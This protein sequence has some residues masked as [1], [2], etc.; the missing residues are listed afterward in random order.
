VQQL[1]F[2][3]EIKVAHS[4][5]FTDHAVNFSALGDAHTLVLSEIG[6]AIV[7]PQPGT[8]AGMMAALSTDSD[9][10][11]AAVEPETFVF[12][13]ADGWQEYLRGFA[14]A[15][16]RIQQDLVGGGAA[17]APAELHE[18]AAAAAATWGLVATRVTS[19]AF[20][21]RGIKVAVLDT[22]F[23]LHHP[24][25]AGRSI[26]AVSFISGQTAQD[27]HGHGTHTTGTACGPRAPAGGVPRYGIAYESQIFMGKVLS[28]TGSSVGGSVLSGM[29]WAIA[30]RC[31]VISM[32]LGGHSP[33]QAG[34]TQAGQAALNAGL[35]IIAASGNDSNRPTTIA[36][37]GSP[38]NSPTIMAV[39]SLDLNLGVSFFSNG[40][41]VEIAGPGRDVA[42]SAPMPRRYATMSGTSMAT[43]HVAGVAALYAQ[44]NPALRG[45]PL[46]RML[47]ARARHLPLPPR[48]V[49]AGL[50]QAP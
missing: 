11:I 46:W 1:S 6:V 35:L 39:A 13:C 40:G 34:Y 14:A 49:G 36:P 17:R 31:E 23:D 50:V 10:A 5:D 12:A 16:E 8:E 21:G 28:N 45:T 20:S 18:D 25:F 37:T 2:S 7:A 47:V 9:S 30:N 48:D 26:T 32:S 38:A 43:P 44:S 33:P 29:N 41:K 24:D 19:S 27:G 3:T 4:S 42:S 15:A 22:G